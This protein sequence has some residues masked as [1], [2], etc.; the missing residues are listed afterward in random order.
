MFI[1]RIIRFQIGTFTSSQEGKYQLRNGVIKH[2]ETEERRGYDSVCLPSMLG[3]GHPLL[4]LCKLSTVAHACY[5]SSPEV[6]A[7]GSEVQS[8]S[9]R[10][11][12]VRSSV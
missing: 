12:Y 7:G 2:L 3:A 8:S 6:E 10:P 11:E 9:A 4:A 5:P 1:V